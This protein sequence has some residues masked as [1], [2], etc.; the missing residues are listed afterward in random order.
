MK[1]EPLSLRR[2]RLMIAALATAA[3]PSQLL[4]APFLAPAAITGYAD[5]KMVISG[6]VLDKSGKPLFGATVEIIN[7]PVSRLMPADARMNVLTVTDADGRFMLQT[8]AVPATTRSERFDYRVTHPEHA[9]FS[10]RL[11]LAR[12]G[13]QDAAGV[14]LDADGVW[15]TTLGIT[16]A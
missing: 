6:R 10:A 4:A 9:S 12:N 8:A 5:G 13:Q 11:N 7:S 1:N 3:A 16:V 2:R 14:Q 15:R